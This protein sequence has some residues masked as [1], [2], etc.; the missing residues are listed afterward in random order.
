MPA[1]ARSHAVVTHPFHPLRGTRLAV[2]S[3]EGRQLRCGDPESGY[4][5][6]PRA[7]TDLATPDAFLSAAR[8]RSMLR[9]DKLLELAD[10]LDRLR[11]R[12]T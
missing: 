11:V 3:H 5:F 8:G 4:R 10:L 7:W 12:N 2:V 1:E 6:L 9:P